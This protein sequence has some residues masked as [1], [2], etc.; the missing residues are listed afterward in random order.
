[1]AGTPDVTEDAGT[2]G[3]GPVWGVPLGDD[4]AAALDLTSLWYEDDHGTARPIWDV[5]VEVAR[6]YASPGGPVMGDVPWDR[7]C[8]AYG[9]ATD[10]PE[11][12][13]QVRGGDDAAAKQALIHLDN[14]ICHQGGSSVAAPFCIPFLLRS[15]VDAP[16]PRRVGLVSVAVA[17]GRDNP[18]G[19]LRT[20]VLNAVAGE[21]AL[22]VDNC[23]YPMNWTQQAARDALAADTPLLARLLADADAGT[24][25]CAAF[26]LAT[27]SAA[28]GETPTALLR[29]Q[30][31]REAQ[32]AVCAGLV[33]AIAERMSTYGSRAEGM[34]W[35]QSVW[36]DAGEP[37]GTRLAAAVGWLCLTDVPPPEQLSELVTDE[38]SRGTASVLL[39]ARWLRHFDFDRSDGGVDRWLLRLLDEARTDTA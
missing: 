18:F 36:E 4:D 22:M 14:K 37:P 17:A 28:A 3:P 2:P 20:D 34:R 26:A 38:V 10:V 6:L 29:R 35:A 5:R 8:H 33:L 15:A 32:A 1:M 13:A 9:W 31:S 24:R 16:A 21:T 23:G 12:L 19:T 7:L 30:L 39:G 11:L 27:A 25:A